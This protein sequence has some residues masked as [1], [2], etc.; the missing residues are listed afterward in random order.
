L[1][2]PIEPGDRANWEKYVA[3]HGDEALFKGDIGEA[4]AAL[5]A[6]ATDPAA[7]AAASLPPKIEVSQDLDKGLA[8]S[9]RTGRP[10]TPGALYNFYLPWRRTM[11]LLLQVDAANTVDAENSLGVLI[12]LLTMW[13]STQSDWLFSFCRLPVPSMEGYAQIYLRAVSIQSRTMQ[14]DGSTRPGLPGSKAKCAEES[15]ASGWKAGNSWAPTATAP[16]LGT[17]SVVE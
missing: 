1:V 2:S 9:C 3:V 10:M 8:F 11:K 17:R 13:G 4:C 5:Q 12:H 6:A 15:S 7:P 16:A 14:P